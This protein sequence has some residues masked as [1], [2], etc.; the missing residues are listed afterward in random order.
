MRYRLSLAR[1]VVVFLLLILFPVS[2][3]AVVFVDGNNTKGPWDG[4]SWATAYITVQESLE[5]ADKADEEVWVAKGTYKPTTKDD[6][7][8]SFLLKPGVAL[9]GGFSGNET[10]LDQR[11]W[12]KNISV[13]SGEI[14]DTDNKKDNSYHVLIGAD[15]AIIDGFTITG[16]YAVPKGGWE[17][18]LHAGSGAGGGP[19]GKGFPKGKAV[20][21]KTTAGKGGGP[22]GGGPSWRGKVEG[23]G[24]ENRACSPIIRNCVFRDN[25]AGKGGGIYNA[26]RRGGPGGGRSS[27]G[28][29]PA[30]TVINCTFIDNGAIARGG[31]MSNDF[32]SHPTITGCSFINNYCDDAKGGGVYN[33]FG[34]SP[35]IINC[36]FVGNSAFRAGALGNDG[37]S[38]PTITNCTFVNNY[39]G[40]IGASIYQGTGS[41]NNPV[42]TNC[43]VWDNS[44][45]SGPEGIVNWHDCV[46]D[47]SYSCIEGGYKGPGNID[48]N[49][50]FIDAKNGDFRLGAGSPCVD[51]GN[52]YQAPE[53]DMAGNPKYDDKGRPDG[54]FARAMIRSRSAGGS[55]RR[56][57][58][59][60]LPVDM[61]VYERQSDTKAPS[62]ATIYVDAD[63]KKGPW[64]GKKWATAYRDLQ[65]ALDYAYLSG[66][67]I[68][69]AEGTYKP[70]NSKDR[71]VSIMLRDGVA[72]Y[73]GFKGNEK[74]II[75]RDWGK[76]VTVLSGDIGIAGDYR[77]NSFHVLIG[78][79]DAILDGFTITAGNA[80][81][82]TYNAKGG[83]MINYRFHF[84]SGPMGPSNGYSPSIANCTFI[85]NKA[86]EGGAVYSYDRGNITFENCNFIDNSAVNGGAIL[87]R[88]GVQTA[89]KQC[90]FKNNRAELR[91]GALY[92]DYGSR[93][94]V[95]ECTFEENTTSGNGG[96]IYTLSRASQLEN[97]LLN[98]I[99]SNFKENI[100]GMRGGAIA[101]FDLSKIQ[102]SKSEFNNNKAS[103]GG[104]AVSNDYRAEATITECKFSNN[105]AK[106]GKADIDSDKSSKIKISD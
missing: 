105:S 41:A 99:S 10:K 80:D 96:A 22:S 102:V 14:G 43:I 91:G 85:N 72:M 24:M 32:G 81:D 44:T 8:V 13:L 84:Q 103:K 71:A 68:W 28:T 90:E 101:N 26:A 54:P 46:P 51:T 64:D 17:A 1:C 34:C 83:G 27:E 94:T 36:L 66:A 4:N 47:V 93:A 86:I 35:T 62:Q 92:L 38:S 50:N 60:G 100:A 77:D 29:S 69:V 106:E 87:D 37:G 70:S 21:G 59:L 33:D 75:K 7:S 20:S 39:A 61:G 15:D 16:G 31:A 57:R 45:P 52:C 74:S 63:N 40:D 12:E 19:Q 25:Y 2:S 104:G 55:G 9:Y 76:N 5:D 65:G 49:P 56:S 73:G 79:N 97:T 89:L 6:R 58:N 30:P 88:V 53:K 42:V 48:V 11:D 67:E 3:W 95:A 78:A 23:G 98:V 18:P 82:D